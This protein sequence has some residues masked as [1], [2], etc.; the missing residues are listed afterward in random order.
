[1]SPEEQIIVGLCGIVGIIVGLI[2]GVFLTATF[3]YGHR[4]RILDQQLWA[5]EK[6]HGDLPSAQKGIAVSSPGIED[7]I[8]KSHQARFDQ[9]LVGPVDVSRLREAIQRVLPRE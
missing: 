7:D 4:Q 9:D 2:L 6:S 8:C 1:M 5:S 3:T